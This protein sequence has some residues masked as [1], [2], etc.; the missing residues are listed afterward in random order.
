[1]P[2]GSEGANH[3]AWKKYFKLKDTKCK[4]SEAEGSSV[5]RRTR[6]PELLRV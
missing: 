1:M 5:L 3:R 6:R 2:E 4:S